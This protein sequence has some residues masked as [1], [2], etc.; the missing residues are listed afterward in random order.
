M[1][2]GGGDAPFFL[3]YFCECVDRLL[4]VGDVFVED[5]IECRVARSGPLSLV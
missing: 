4:C 5:G 1:R 2:E 3:L